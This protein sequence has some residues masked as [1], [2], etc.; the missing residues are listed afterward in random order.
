VSEARRQDW[1]LATFRAREA[2]QPARYEL[3]NGAPR[4][5]TGGS[6]AHAL[7]GGNIVAGL[8]PG[9]RGSAC[10]PIGSDLRVVT[11]NGNVRY[12]DALIDCGPFRPESHDA[13]QPVAGFEALSRSTAWIDLYAKLRD[14]DAT[15]SIQLYAVVAQDEPHVAIWR[16]DPSGRLAVTT[17]LTGRDAVLELH[18]PAPADLRLADIYDGLP[19][20]AAAPA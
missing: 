4:L 5:M 14:Y 13:S 8:N 15:P 19:G 16:R 6:Q 17:A 3:V 1:D 7:I 9:L 10:R 12:P 20:P 18:L 2:S 11:G